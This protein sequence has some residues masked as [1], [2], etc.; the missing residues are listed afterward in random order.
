M[1]S[2]ISD[3]SFS[4]VFYHSKSCCSAFNSLKELNLK[5]WKFTLLHKTWIGQGTMT[6]WYK[7]SK[8]NG[9][10]VTCCHQNIRAKYPGKGIGDYEKLLGQKSIEYKEI[11]LQ[12][13]CCKILIF[14]FVVEHHVEPLK[15]TIE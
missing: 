5:E 3:H 9:V 1:Q 14:K 10:T 6:S 4:R 11:Y 15:N 8:D 13:F 7:P 2:Q 12:I